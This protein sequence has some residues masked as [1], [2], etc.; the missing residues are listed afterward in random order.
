[1]YFKVTEAV[2]GK[3]SFIYLQLWAL[4]RQAKP[5]SLKKE[6]GYPYVSSSDIPIRGRPKPRPLSGDEVQHY[7]ELYAKAAENA[8]KVGIAD[9][10]SILY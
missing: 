1:L 9:M 5:E 10:I 4:G 6:G 8:I 7:V 3:Q 2:H